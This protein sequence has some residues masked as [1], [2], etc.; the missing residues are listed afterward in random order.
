MARYVESAFDAQDIVKG[1]SN[2]IFL[3]LSVKAIFAVCGADKYTSHI[4]AVRH[5]KSLLSSSEHEENRIPKIATRIYIYNSFSSPY[6]NNDSISE[7][8]APKYSDFE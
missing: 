7:I 8:S 2:E 5:D 4:S 1:F 6:Y 3:S